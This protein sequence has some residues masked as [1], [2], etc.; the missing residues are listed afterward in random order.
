MIVFVF[1]LLIMRKMNGVMIRFLNRAMHYILMT[2][3]ILIAEF[4]AFYQMD[5]DLLPAKHNLHSIF[6][7]RDS[8]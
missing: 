7:I 4:G 3:R 8:L 6:A 1:F 5:E 2:G